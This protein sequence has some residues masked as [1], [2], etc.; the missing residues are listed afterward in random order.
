MTTCFTLEEQVTGPGAIIFRGAGYRLEKS[1]NPHDG[2]LVHSTHA[3]A[4]YPLE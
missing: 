2:F 4:A 3:L 1:T